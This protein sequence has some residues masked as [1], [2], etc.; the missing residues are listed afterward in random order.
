[1]PIAAAMNTAVKTGEIPQMFSE[2]QCRQKWVRMFKADKSVNA[3]SSPVSQADNP[4]T[5]AAAAPA[6]VSLAPLVQAALWRPTSGQAVVVV[7]LH[8]I[9]GTSGIAG[10]ADWQLIYSFF[11]TFCPRSDCTK[12]KSR[13]SGRTAKHNPLITRCHEPGSADAT[14]A[15]LVT[16]LRHQVEKAVGAEIAERQK[17]R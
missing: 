2:T 17:L 8:E 4:L 10:R 13:T 14:Y 6:S 12:S 15:V 1:M 9:L 7:L 11:R 16:E 3:G 5:R